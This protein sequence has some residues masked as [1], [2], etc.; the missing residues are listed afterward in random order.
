MVDTVGTVFPSYGKMSSSLAGLPDH[1]DHADHA[2]WIYFFGLVA[3][4]VAFSD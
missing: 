2:S 3:A 4:L 1:A